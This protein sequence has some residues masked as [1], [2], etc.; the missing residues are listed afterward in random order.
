MKGVVYVFVFSCKTTKKQL[1]CVGLCVL[2]A[3]GMLSTGALRRQ[4]AKPTAT[5]FTTDAGITY[6]Q[7]C[8][9]TATGGTITD[10]QIPDTVDST[11]TMY[12]QTAGIDIA[13]LLGKTVQ[14]CT[15]TVTNHPQGA[16]TAQLYLYK[17]NIVAATLTVNGRLYPLEVKNGTAG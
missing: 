1:F 2:L 15:Y 13:P 6:L 12:A 3:I 7:S 5:A 14:C 16:A 8:G 11:V 10:I 17:E 4:D 9:Y